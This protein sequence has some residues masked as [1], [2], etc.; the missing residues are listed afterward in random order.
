MGC[1]VPLKTFYTPGMYSKFPPRYLRAERR[2]RDDTSMEIEVKL[3]GIFQKYVPPG[4]ENYSCRLELEEGAAIDQ[5][6]EKL[7]IPRYVPMV[8]LVNGIPIT[9]KVRL[10]PGDELKITPL[11]TGG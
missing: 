3:F 9:A 10:H 5:V 1:K 11:V 2:K 4:S 7:K 6:L 8:T